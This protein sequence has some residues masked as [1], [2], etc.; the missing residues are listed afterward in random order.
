MNATVTFLNSEDEIKNIRVGVF[1]VIMSER[2]VGLNT[3]NG[4][5][6]LDVLPQA[7]TIGDIEKAVETSSTA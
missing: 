3:Y 5:F 2:K 1:I 6:W 4:V 7:E